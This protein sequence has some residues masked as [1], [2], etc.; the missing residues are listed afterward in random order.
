MNP[1][2]IHRVSED[3]SLDVWLWR[4]DAVTKLMSS[5]SDDIPLESHEI[6]FLSTLA[7]PNIF[8]YIGKIG[9]QKIGVCRFN[10]SSNKKIATVSIQLNPKK[11]GQNL[12]V[13]LLNRCIELFTLEYAKCITLEAKVRVEN[14]ASLKCFLRCE[15]LIQ[16][17]SHGFYTL[18]LER[19]SNVKP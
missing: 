3:D 4:T 8:F 15:F 17:N 10:I 19:N 1:M 7:D 11:R 6:W 12:S 5:N 14:V 18:T 9:D 16:N 2:L 13:A